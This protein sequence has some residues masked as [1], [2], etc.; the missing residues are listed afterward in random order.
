MNLRP[1]GYEPDEL[2]DC[3]TPQLVRGIIVAH[4]LPCNTEVERKPGQADSGAFA[5]GSR[6]PPRAA[7]MRSATRKA[8]A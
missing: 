8:L 5:R 1:S 3:S 2:P 6:A 4:F 7:M